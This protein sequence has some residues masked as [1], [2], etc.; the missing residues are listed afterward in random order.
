MLKAVVPPERLFFFSV[1]EGWEP[2]CKA[3]GKEIPDVPFPNINDGKAIDALA[4]RMVKKGLLRWA[5]ILATIGVGVT[6]W[7]MMR[8][9][10]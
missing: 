3:L 6:S 9:T 2:L 7:S 8:T 5:L 10:H 4:V 1:K